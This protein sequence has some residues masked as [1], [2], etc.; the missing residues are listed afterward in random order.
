MCLPYDE[1][2]TY[3]SRVARALAKFAGPAATWPDFTTLYFEETDHVG[4]EMGT[5]CPE[6]RV[7]TGFRR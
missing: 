6:V 2:E 7:D 5:D 1:R 4:H 3:E